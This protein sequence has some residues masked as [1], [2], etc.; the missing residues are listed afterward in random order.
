MVKALDENASYVPAKRNW[1]KVGRGPNRWQR[2]ALPLG[3]VPA[4]VRLRIVVALIAVVAAAVVAAV[5]VAA[6]A[7]AVT[8]VVGDRSRAPRPSRAWA[9][10][11][12]AASCVCVLV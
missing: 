4:C 10:G 12:A 2:M 3:S 6:V 5:A 11:R 8:A 7:V 9:R 1:L